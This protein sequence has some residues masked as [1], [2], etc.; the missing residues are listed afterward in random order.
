VWHPHIYHRDRDGEIRLD[1]LHK[2]MAVAPASRTQVLVDQADMI[3]RLSQRTVPEEADQ[4][5]V[6]ARYE[7][8][9]ALASRP[10]RS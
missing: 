4:S 8:L 6:T 9:L 5:D 7:A 1:A 10:V 3:Q 2:I